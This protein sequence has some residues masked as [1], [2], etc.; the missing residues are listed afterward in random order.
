MALVGGGYRHS[1]TG[2]FIGA[3][4]LDG[5]NPSYHVWTQ[6]MTARSKNISA[7][8]AITDDKFSVPSGNRHPVAWIMPRKAGGLSSNFALTMSM[9]MTGSGVYGRNLSVNAPFS[10]DVSQANLALVVGGVASISASFTMTPNPNLVGVLGAASSF[11]GME[12][13]VNPTLG[14]KSGLG[15]TIP[16]TFSLNSTATAKG[17]LSANITGEGA[18]VT[19]TSVAAEVWNTVAAAFNTA[20]TMG[21]K[22]NSAASAGDPWTTPLP[23]SYL[24]GTAGQIIGT[25]QND[26]NLH[27][28]SAVATQQ[29]LLELASFGSAV[30]IDALN[31]S[32]GT[33]YPLGTHTNPV[34]NMFDAL[35]IASA[36]GVQ[37]IAVENAITMIASDVLDNL[38][39]TSESWPAIT[40]NT[41]IQME[42]TV[43]ERVSLY[44]EFEGFWNTINDCWV[45]DITNFSGWVRGG[46]IGSVSLAVGL[47]LEF[48]GQ[49]FFD[50]IVPLFPGVPSEITANTNSEISITNCADLVTLKSMTAGC[51]AYIGLSGGTIT[52]DATCTGGTIVVSGVG[53]LVNES[54]VPVDS[55]GLAVSLVAAEAAPIHADI[56]KVNNITVDGVGSEANPWGPV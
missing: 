51:K 56:R 45:Y 25:L 35:V 15:V 28:D 33:A 38:T 22:M 47:G 19:P 26:I 5:A 53:T 21:N 54:A 12:F 3:T 32:P 23:G 14:A 8:E 31:G 4:N 55:E 20:G 24:A 39:I 44:G 43:F 9:T 2:K 13:T 1:L 36:N 6:H 10:L 27:T 34:D 7:S 46:A 48:G 41:G 11:T 18:A 16:M 50:N 42:N 37:R 49:C 17:S 40:L 30:H 29:E 52:I